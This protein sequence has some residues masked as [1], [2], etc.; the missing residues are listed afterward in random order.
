MRGVDTNVL[1]RFLTGDDP[2]QYQTAER[3]F[4]A[5]EEAGESL[6]LTVPVLCELVWT[7]RGRR[8]RHGGE[9]IVGVLDRL[10]ATPTIEIQD[11]D[12]VQRAL[13]DYEQG[14]GDFADYLIGHLARKAGCSET[15]TFDRRLEGSPLF[16]V[17]G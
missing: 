2:E 16:D 11:R 10:L 1:V 3:L 5:A 9:A 7:L 4:V 15:V 6:Y 14:Q 12:A 17:L 8:Y 13:I